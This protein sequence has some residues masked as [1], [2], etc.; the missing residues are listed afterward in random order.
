MLRQLLRISW[1]PLY[2]RWALWYVRRERPFRFGA[3][4]LRVPVGVFHPGV[5]FSSP[6]MLDFL[7]KQ[8]LN[9][10]KILDLG[11]G[12]GVLALQAA[13]QKALVTAVDIHP[14]ALET[15][16][17]NA[18]RNGLHLR[19]LCSDLLEHVPPE[20]FDRV[21]INPPFYPKNPA[22]L[23]EHAF[24]A[25]ENL[26]Y[27]RRLFRSLPNYLHAESRVWMILSEDCRLVEIQALATA[28]RLGWEIVQEKQ[29]WGER[30]YLVAL[31]RTV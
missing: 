5:Y 10:L 4:R 22:N 25:G 7:Q 17:A 3:L 12:S 13:A 20:V 14:L 30:F 19:C 28:N 21:L 2:R 8:D 23:P 15:A 11:T 27:F 16:L 1:L 18:A 31:R 9:G 6:I 29:K 26:N 24:F